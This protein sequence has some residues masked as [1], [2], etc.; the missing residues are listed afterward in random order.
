M[1][2]PSGWNPSCGHP[3]A[4]EPGLPRGLHIEGP[5]F[6]SGAKPVQMPPPGVAQARPGNFGVFPQITL[7]PL[8]PLG[9]VRGLPGVDVGTS[10]PVEDFY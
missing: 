8:G 1:A 4:G 7:L 3:L 5:T 10:K 9:G 6:D 2:L